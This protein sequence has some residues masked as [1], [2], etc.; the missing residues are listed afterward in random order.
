MPQRK[1]HDILWPHPAR[2]PLG[3]GY[4]GCCAAPGHEGAQ[5]S[6]LE[7]K[8]MCNLGYAKGCTRLPAERKADAVRFAVSLDGEERIVIA[9]VFE[10]DHA[11]VENG[12]AEYDCVTSILRVTPSDLPMKKQMECFLASYLERRPRSQ[13]RSTTG[14]IELIG[15]S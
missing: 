12:N 9:Y 14:P 10:R 6:D 11:P 13:M 7:L 1:C 2:L 5:P 8:D 4:T 3:Y 15:K